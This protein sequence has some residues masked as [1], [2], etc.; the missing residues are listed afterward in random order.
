MAGRVQRDDPDA[1]G[2]LE[3]LAVVEPDVAVAKGLVAPVDHLRTALARELGRAH[4]EILLAMGLDR[5]LDG[6]LVLARQRQVLVDITARIDHRGLAL[7]ADQVRDV[8]DAGGL[9]AFEV[10]EA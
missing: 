1:L 2:D 10:H 9:N 7:V 3:R 4:H 8:G 5:V 6:Q